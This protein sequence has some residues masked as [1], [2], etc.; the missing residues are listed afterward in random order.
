M[1]VLEKILTDHGREEIVND[2]MEFKQEFLKR[3][4]WEKGTPKR[5][6][7]LTSYSG[8]L[9]K[10]KVTVPGHVRAA[11][12]WNTLREMHGDKMA[13]PINDGQKAVVCYLK[14]NPMGWDS[15]AYPTD[16]LR[17]PKWFLELPFDEQ[18]MEQ[19]VVNKKLEN[20]LG[21]LKWDITADIDTSNT[22]GS[23]FD[24]E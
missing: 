11:M 1:K 8:R 16:E 3:N 17:L 9:E 4:P 14:P 18:K 24:F 13:L 7:N 23:L 5:V 19:T 15:V 2:I 20:L 10:G 6:N 22:F 21:V 12:H